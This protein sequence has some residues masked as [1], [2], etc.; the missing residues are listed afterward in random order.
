[1][2]RYNITNDSGC[3]YGV[4][5]EESLEGEWVKYEDVKYILKQKKASHKP[6]V[7]TGWL[8]PDIEDAN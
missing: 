6:I 4:T 5:P 1:M 7:L 3:G 8:A 2:K